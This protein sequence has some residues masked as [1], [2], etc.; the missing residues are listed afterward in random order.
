MLLERVKLPLV[1][2]FFKWL[3]ISQFYVRDAVLLQVC[4]ANLQQDTFNSPHFC[5]CFF[6]YFPLKYRH[7]WWRLDGLPETLACRPF[8]PLPARRTLFCQNQHCEKTQGQP[9]AC[10]KAQSHSFTPSP[11]ATPSWFGW[12]SK[13]TMISSLTPRDVRKPDAVTAKRNA[14]NSELWLTHSF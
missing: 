3:V 8:R 6:F 2:V 12:R 14:C 1:F 10:L 13:Q 4:V 11:S 7:L 9:A 5:V